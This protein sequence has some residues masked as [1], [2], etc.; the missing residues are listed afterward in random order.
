MS[1]RRTFLQSALFLPSLLS[2]H[3]FAQDN[4]TSQATRFADFEGG[5]WNDWTI[6]GEAFGTSPATDA[7]FPGKIR[8]FGGNGFV[9]TLH[10]KK[11]NAAVGKAVSREFTIEK[12]FI[13]F[14]IGGGN[15]P[16][17][18]CLNLVVDGQVIRT[19]TGNGTPNLSEVS[20]D[21][22]A[23]VGKKARL[24][25]VDSTSSAQRGY[26]LVDDIA[27]TMGRNTP[28]QI[29]LDSEPLLELP[30]RVIQVVDSQG[31][32]GFYKNRLG[33]IPVPFSVPTVNEQIR[34]VNVFFRPANIK[35]TLDASTFEL[36]RD[37]YLNL[38]SD[39]PASDMDVSNRNLKPLD[40][41]VRERL[42][43]FQKLSDERKDLITV[44]YH[45]GSEWKWNEGNQRWDFDVG[46]SHG[47]PGIKSGRGYYIR[48]V[49]A[50]PRVI[51]HE[52]G[53]A[54]GLPHTYIG[55]LYKRSKLVTEEEI[56]AACQDYIDNGGDPEHPEY[57]I[58]GD[59][60]AG[61]FDTPPDPGDAFWGNSR[62]LTRTVEIHRPNTDPFR[63]L[64]SRNN[65]MA[66][67][68][69]NGG[70]TKGQI[71]VMRRKIEE[72]KV[73]VPKG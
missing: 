37:D 11:G 73:R 25:I 62:D 14:K 50:R 17:Q 35:V 60:Q 41:G 55:D 23:L 16:G 33:D 3:A 36:R 61:I 70:F 34:A 1:T 38:D 51:A 7:L 26:V 28:N 65:I 48:I 5:A 21:V 22:S 54:L 30:L 44:I 66:T 39:L 68:S 43:A 18:A 57:A 49:G 52:L 10:P 19:A 40:V 12:P 47:G 15:F 45:R 32:V 71:A 56:S 69:D 67:R 64:V 6:E 59:I 31:K 13:T 58:D 63:I 46:F 27:F 42:N 72:W 8:G 53:H 4:Q 2:A 29:L 20:W 24:E 9:C